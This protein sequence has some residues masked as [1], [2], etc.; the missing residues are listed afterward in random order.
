MLRSQIISPDSSG[1]FELSHKV[2]EPL[3]LD[4]VDQRVSSRA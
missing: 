3:C 4:R 2:R 1:L